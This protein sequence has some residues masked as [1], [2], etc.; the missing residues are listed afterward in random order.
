MTQVEIQKRTRSF[1]Q[2]NFIQSH[3]RK[4]Q[5]RKW[6]VNLGTYDEIMQRTKDKNI[7]HDEKFWMTSKKNGI[8]KNE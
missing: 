5:R 8:F 6:I 7:E 2:N 3:P 1:Y 4:A